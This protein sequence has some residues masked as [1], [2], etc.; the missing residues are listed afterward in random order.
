MSRTTASDRPRCAAAPGHVGVGPAVLVPAEAGELVLGGQVGHDL[1]LTIG[2]SDRSVIT[3]P[4]RVRDV[5][6]AHPVAVRDGGESLH[7]GTHEVR[8]RPRSPPHTAAGT[9][10]RRAPPGSGAGTAGRRRRSRSRRQRSPRRSARSASASA[11]A[12]SGRR[13]RSASAAGQRA[14]SAG[15]PVGGERVDRR[16]RRR[17]RRSSAARRRP[18]RRRCAG[19][20]GPAPASVS[21]NDPGRSAPAALRLRPD[22]AGQRRHRRR[23]SRRGAGG[24]R[25]GSARARRPARRRSPRRA[26]AAAGHPVAGASV[27]PPAWPIAFR[28]PAPGSTVAFFTTP[29]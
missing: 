25:P 10:R 27:T 22:L 21:R 28:Q 3:V 19:P 9:R 5:R 11:R 6:G 12:R 24:W 16:P 2:L 1:V 8:D 18:G 20:A 15:D 14:S 4:A 13:R 29:V 23:A 7:V 26:P 17:A